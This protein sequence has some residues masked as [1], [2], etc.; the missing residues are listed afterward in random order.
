MIKEIDR[1]KMYLFA[2]ILEQRC[3]V[4]KDQNITLFSEDSNCYCLVFIGYLLLFAGKTYVF[5]IFTQKNYSEKLLKNKIILQ[6]QGILNKIGPH[7]IKKRT[8]QNQFACT[9]THD[10]APSG[11]NI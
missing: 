1:S 4:K 8:F 9:I 5:N 6:Q 2:L 3:G 7:K 10:Q 11:R